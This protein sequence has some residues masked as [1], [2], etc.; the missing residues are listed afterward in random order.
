MPKAIERQTERFYPWQLFVFIRRPSEGILAQDTSGPF[1]MSKGS[2]KS[3]RGSSGESD[4][5]FLPGARNGISVSCKGM[6]EATANVALAVSGLTLAKQ[7]TADCG[8]VRLQIYF[9]F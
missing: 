2:L 3:K 6:A 8:K 5:A 7:K 4:R 9:G 1:P